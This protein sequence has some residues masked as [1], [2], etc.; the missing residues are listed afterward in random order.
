[1]VDYGW[2]CNHSQAVDDMHYLETLIYIH[3]KVDII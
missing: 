3:V 1:M 2:S